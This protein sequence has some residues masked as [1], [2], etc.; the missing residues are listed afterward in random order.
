MGQPGSLPRDLSFAPLAAVAGVQSAHCC[1]G[2]IP[3][4]LVPQPAIGLGLDGDLVR[5]VA[6]FLRD[7][8]SLLPQSRENL[9]GH[10]LAWSLR[11]TFSKKMSDVPNEIGRAHV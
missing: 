2:R 3:C 1:H 10:Y 9:C 5:H 8:S 4:V 7:W 6:H 11:K